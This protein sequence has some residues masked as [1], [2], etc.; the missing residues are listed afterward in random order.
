MPASVYGP[1]SRQPVFTGNR[2]V[3]GL[4]ERTVK[5]GTIVYEA[6]GR[7]G[8]KLRRHTLKARTKTF[9]LDILAACRDILEHSGH[10]R[11]TIGLMQE[12]AQVRAGEA[13]SIAI[14]QLRCRVV[15]LDDAPA[16]HQLAGH[17][18]RRRFPDELLVLRDR[19]PVA[20]VL[21][22]AARVVGSARDD[23]SRARLGEVLLDATLD[24]ADLFRREDATQADGAFA[25]KV[26]SEAQ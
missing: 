12:G 16:P 9:A 20:E 26:V 24:E 2:R 5:D 4:Y 10:A 23:R 22:E 14:H 17:R 8:G 18:R 3:P 7:M 15:R 11:R 13:C 6:Q 21:H 1:N 25:A 19:L